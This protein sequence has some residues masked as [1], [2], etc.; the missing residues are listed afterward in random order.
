MSSLYVMQNHVGFI[1]I[2]RSVD[3]DKRRRQIEMTDECTVALVAVIPDAGHDEETMLLNLADHQ[4][5]GEWFLGDELCRDCVAIEI[6]ALCEVLGRDPPALEW[7]FPVASEA[8]TE[9]WLDRCEQRRTVASIN[10]EYGRRIRAMAESSS[11][12]SDPS[13]YND[14]SLWSLLWRFERQVGTIVTPKTGKKGETVLVGHREGDAVGE[15]VPHYS[16]DVTAALLLW[17]DADRPEAWSG[18]AWD[19][20]IAAL[21]AR[22][23]RLASDGL[24]ALWPND[25]EIPVGKP[26]L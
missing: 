17:P 7:P 6:E 3:V 25:A 4:V 13:R 1:K 15:I 10:R 16:T 26:Y 19:C 2:G 12:A 11:S 8:A 24:A 14:V 21:K 20:C 23:A 9:A 22:K 5:I 18:S